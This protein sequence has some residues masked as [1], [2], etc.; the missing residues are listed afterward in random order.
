MSFH[1]QVL[2]FLAC[3]SSIAFLRRSCFSCIYAF[4]LV[5]TFLNTNCFFL[6]SSVFAST[7]FIPGLSQNEFISGLFSVLSP[8]TI[9]NG[10]LLANYP[11]KKGHK[12]TYMMA[13]LSGH[14]NAFECMKN[15]RDFSTTSRGAAQSQENEVQ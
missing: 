6:Q 4:L 14:S 7:Y 8:K 13:S 3:H 2:H 5:I 10:V 11:A 9:P 15:A 1:L 12:W